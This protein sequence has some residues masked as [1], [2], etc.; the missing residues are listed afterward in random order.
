[1]LVVAALSG[2]LGTVAKG[3]T[4]TTRP[5]TT[6]VGNA[7]A[8]SAVV[9]PD[10]IAGRRLGDVLDVARAGSLTDERFAGLFSAS[11]R[12]KVSTTQLVAIFRSALGASVRVE[13]VLMSVPTSIS[14]VVNGVGGQVK[15]DLATDAA[16][17]IFG[18]L[19]RPYS[20][21][22][23][24]KEPKSWSEIDVRIGKVAPTTAMVAATIDNTGKCKVRHGLRETAPGPLGSMFKLYV[25]AAV[26]DAV[27]RRKLT[28]DTNVKVRDDWKSLPSG[29]MQNE[30]AG[31]SH[32]VAEVANAMISISDNTATDHLLRTV[33]RG[34]V[35][36]AMTATGIRNAS[37][38]VPFL[39]TRDLFV[40]KGVNYPSLAS[41]YRTLDLAAKRALLD[42]EVAA[43]PLTDFTMW[44][45]PRDI[46]SL[47]W[48]ASPMDVCG[49]FAYL[50]A[51]A[52]GPS[53][54]AVN[55]AL[56]INDGGLSLDA[57]TWPSVWFKG[58]SEPGVLT[59]GFYAERATGE[60]MVVVTM[61]SDTTRAFDEQPAAV[62]LESLTRGA[63]ALMK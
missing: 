61:V 21:A 42:G 56:S 58:G 31:T 26:A 52:T 32:T 22:P 38:N 18:L 23:P 6:S 59:L 54:K 27:E 14:V 33:G 11:F 62:E 13:R 47:E 15:I 48:F 16:R 53:G 46:E 36:A 20:D 57:K 39:T 63:F 30:A 8:A 60:R 4:S 10:T 17:Q 24:P 44:S 41:K 51:K 35:E 28:W 43:K 7:R 9:I 1:V 12:S 55:H 3:A 37:R 50:R 34:T 19:L 25:L 2:S 40:L 5:A 45:P 49:A 29:T